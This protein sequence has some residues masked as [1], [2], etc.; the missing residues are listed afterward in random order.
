MAGATEMIAES[1]ASVRFWR[2]YFSVKDEDVVRESAKI[3]LN[4]H[5]TLASGNRSSVY[6]VAYPYLQNY[7]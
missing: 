3:F 4:L 1:G 2:P 7:M 6:Y 5:S